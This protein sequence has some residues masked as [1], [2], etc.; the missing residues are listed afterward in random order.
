MV[1][2]PMNRDGWTDD[3]R[4]YVNATYDTASRLTEQAWLDAAKAFGKFAEWV[5]ANPAPG[6]D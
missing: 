4:R 2:R 6:P 3:E 1:I 5:A